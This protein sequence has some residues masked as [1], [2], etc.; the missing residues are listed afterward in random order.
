MK[1]FTITLKLPSEVG[2]PFHQRS[3]KLYISETKETF[4][5]LV[6]T[7]VKSSQLGGY[8]LSYNKNRKELDKSSPGFE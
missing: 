2:A 3:C 1:H 5:F 4:L 7:G 8:Q 6:L